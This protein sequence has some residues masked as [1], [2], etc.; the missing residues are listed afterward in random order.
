MYKCLS[1]NKLP[2]TNKNR[3]GSSTRNPR[4]KR[5]K[6]QH[7]RRGGAN[8]RHSVSGLQHTHVLN[9]RNQNK[10]PNPPS[11]NPLKLTRRPTELFE[12]INRPYLSNLFHDS[13]NHDAVE[14]MTHSGICG[15]DL[16][17]LNDRYR[18]VSLGLI[19]STSCGRSTG[20]FHRTP[21]WR[22]TSAGRY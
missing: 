13:V 20:R 12:T 15:L 2:S 4:Y 9:R 3:P 19:R 22:S 6:N 14:T 17:Q 1:T 8:K 21:P 7:P 10:C 11:V 16:K 5:Y 18:L